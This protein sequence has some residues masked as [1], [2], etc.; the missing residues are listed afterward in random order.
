[1]A[2]GDKWVL[3][4]IEIRSFLGVGPSGIS[5]DL[6]RPVI[7][8]HGPSGSGKSTI[9][10]AI[11]WGLFGNIELV[12]DYSITGVGENV[13]THRSFIHNGESGAEVTLKF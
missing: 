10:S 9:V 12:P 8:I 2:N 7:I 13:S 11:E 6:D 3:N 5:I 4:Q 1:M